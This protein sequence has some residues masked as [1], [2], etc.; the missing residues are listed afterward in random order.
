MGRNAK[1]AEPSNICDNPRAV[2]TQRIRRWPRANRNVVPA[3]GADLDTVNAQ[4]A[5]DVL[6]TIRRPR[7]VAMIGEDDEVQ[8]G[9]PRGRRY[10]RLVADAVR[11]R[12]VHV[13][14]APHRTG[15]DSRISAAD[16]PGICWKTEEEERDPGADN[17]Q[18]QDPPSWKSWM[19]NGEASRRAHPKFSVRR[20]GC[21]AGGASASGRPERVRLVRP[22]PS[23]L[24][25]GATEVPESRAA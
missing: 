8:T 7:A 14:G 19:L 16:T 24:R 25:L 21:R 12:R 4:H 23:E 22:F 13:K 6:G 3:V 2:P 9:R 15:R 5:V 18:R 17:R 11:S 10:G 1:P 20:F